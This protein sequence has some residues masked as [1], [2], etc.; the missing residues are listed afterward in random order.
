MKKGLLKTGNKSLFSN[1]NFWM[2]CIALIAYAVCIYSQRHFV[3][4]DV[5]TFQVPWWN[6]IS[7]HGFQGIATLNNPPEAGGAGG[8]YTTIW[9]FLIWLFC[10][11]GLYPYFP[12]EYNIKLMAVVCSVISALAVYFVIKHYRPKAR[13]APTFG[14]VATLFLPSFL[15]DV[16]KTNLPDTLY[17][18]F[19]MLALLAFLKNRKS[20]AWFILGFGICF[21]LMAIYLAP[22]FVYFYI[23]DFKKYS[24]K[25]KLSPLFVLIPIV[26]CSIPNL[27]SGGDF[28]SG[29]V[30]VML[31]R[32]GEAMH[33]NGYSFWQFMPNDAIHFQSFAIALFL[34]SFA[35]IVIF[36][37]R[38]VPDERKREV[39]T[40]VLLPLFPM[41]AYFLLPAQ[42]ELYFSMAAVFAFIIWCVRPKKKTFFVFAALNILLFVGYCTLSYRALPITPV[43]VFD[44]Y[45]LLSFVFACVIGYLGYQIFKNSVY[46]KGRDCGR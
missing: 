19:A 4:M 26:L 17:I 35:A 3:T 31:G 22:F 46:C 15:L 1:L 18:M 28:M 20:A 37:K 44:D 8:N 11:S 32:S 21:K 9:Y 45:Q 27:L 14:M 33:F 43:G 13:Y 36:V 41:V 29:I 23:K 5:P 25:E 12:I 2:I 7:E 40:T 6:Y 30:G 10:E 16:V 42:H 39:E 24:L 34:L 38:F